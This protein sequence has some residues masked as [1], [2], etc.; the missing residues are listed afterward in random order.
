M[1]ICNIYLHIVKFIGNSVECMLMNF[2]TRFFCLDD[3]FLY[4]FG[5]W[6]FTL[7]QSNTQSWLFIFMYYFAFE[8]ILGIVI[9]IINL[10][11][12]VFVILADSVLLKTQKSV[13]EQGMCA[14]FLDFSKN[15]ATNIQLSLFAEKK[16]ILLVFE[17]V[18]IEELKFDHEIVSNFAIL[19]NLKGKTCVEVN[20]KLR[21]YIVFGLKIKQIVR[22]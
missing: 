21:A 11:G 4:F 22:V 2:W 17:L 10:R 9:L 19:L 15:I 13:W 6:S 20:L 18:S 8:W 14:R 16:P 5:Y 1:I 12:E 3:F 7:F